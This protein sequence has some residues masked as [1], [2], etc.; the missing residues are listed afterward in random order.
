MIKLDTRQI[1]DIVY[2]ATVGF[3]CVASIVLANDK[4]N[5]VDER[6]EK[7]R[8]RVTILEKSVI[9]QT[10]DIEHIKDGIDKIQ[11]KL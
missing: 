10:A 9:R 2:M 4:L 11:K 7:T 1:K 6:S 3:L 8:E 5:R